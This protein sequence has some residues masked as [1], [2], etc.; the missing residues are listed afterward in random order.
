[1]CVWGG[2]G[3]W[4]RDEAVILFCE[5]RHLKKFT[6]TTFFRSPDSALTLLHA[7]LF[8][9][10]AFMHSAGLNDVNG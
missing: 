6:P 7:V 1:M 8:M 9:N 10:S 3:G 4:E 5:A 2:V